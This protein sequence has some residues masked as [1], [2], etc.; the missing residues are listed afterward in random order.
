MA[1][2]SYTRPKTP[3]TLVPVG[4]D[5]RLW[6][7]LSLPFLIFLLIPI[8]ALVLRTSPVELAANLAQPQV[9]Q[10]IGISL[11]TSFTAVLVTIFFGTPVAYL[12]AWHQ[13][14]LRRGVDTLIDLPSVLPPAVAGVALLLAFGRRGILGGLLS[15]LGIEIAFTQV[16]IV[17]AQTYVAAPFYIKTA[18]QGFA[19]VD[20][21]LI[22]AASLD[23]ANNW[24]I[25]RYVTV[26]LSWNAM[27]SGSALTWARALG[28]F[29]A[30]IIFAGN[31]P[32]RTQTMPLAVYIGFEIDLDVAITLS[33]I[34][35]G[36]SFIALSV[37][38]GF[39]QDRAP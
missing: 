6:I 35:V 13:L 2:F 8:L 4:W 11:R 18:T 3:E 26:P 7:G 24:Q 32:G 30:T 21:E 9:L 31:L 17:L 25:F 27:L 36:F 14:P 33:V 10:A 22:Q 12:L 20:R 39:L 5:R 15:D 37:I 1:Q 16:A 38:K 34:L 29:G 19:S 28:E 23:G